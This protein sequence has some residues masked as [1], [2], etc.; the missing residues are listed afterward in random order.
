MKKKPKNHTN[1]PIEE[2]KN[3]ILIE[4]LE[5][6]T[7][8]NK[9]NVATELAIKENDKKEEKTDEELVPKEFHD[10]LNIFSEEK[11]HQF[12]EP[13]PWDHKIEMKEG[14]ELKSFKNY[15][16]TLAEQIELD[17]FLEENLEKGYI[18]PSQLPMASPFFF[19]NKKDGKLWPCQDYWYLN[20]W[21]IKNSYPLSLILKI[22]DKL[23]GTKYFTK[24]DVHWGYN[25]IW[26]RKGD[27]WKAAFKTNKGFSELTVMFFGMCNSPAT[28]QSM[29]D[30]IFAT[31]IEG[32]LVIVYMD[33]ILIFAETKEE[34]TQIT[35][36]VLE[37][38]KET[39]YSS[40]PRNANS[41][42]W[43][44]NT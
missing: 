41:I 37:K 29:M 11:A 31:M 17:K 2:D 12:S 36:M 25:N 32:K 6:T 1:N 26:I 8:I 3:A 28:F 30:N 5:E 10:Y 39:I 14:F 7:W 40:R 42:K 35:K 38:L 19:V 24:L 18:R 23:R 44:S 16:L 33:D 43:K 27:E 22:M 4:L 20:D 9:T 15:N 34:L 21:T 13:W